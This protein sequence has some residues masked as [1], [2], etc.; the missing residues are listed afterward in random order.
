M[1]KRTLLIML[2]CMAWGILPL[3]SQPY[4]YEQTLDAEHFKHDA[5]VTGVAVSPDGKYLLSGEEKNIWV[6][7]R[8]SGQKLKKI[9]QLIYGVA[10]LSFS[11]DG[12]K[13]AVE[14]RC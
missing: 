4:V 6:W 3:S 12:S 10:G 7:D 11:P 9:G 5:M 13:L 1:S 14:D 2:L 8:V